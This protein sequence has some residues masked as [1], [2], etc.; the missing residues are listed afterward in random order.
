MQ[1]IDLPQ[2]A[3]ELNGLAEVFDKKPVTEKASKVWFD[4]LREF[5]TE[6]VLGMLIGWPKSYG[7]FPTPAEVWKAC[8]EVGIAER[9]RKALLEK[10]EAIEWERSPHGAKFLEQMRKIIN[11]PARSPR[12]QWEHVLA[13]QRPGSIGYEYAKKVLRVEDRET[14]EDDE[15]QTVNF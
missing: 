13:T 14:G 1:S 8:N 4:T 9:E 7:K 10:R 15:P 2:L 6:R 3:K 5:P 12:Q 11:R